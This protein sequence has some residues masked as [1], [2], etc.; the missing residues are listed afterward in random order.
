ME[1][2][3]LKSYFTSFVYLCKDFRYNYNEILT[4]FNIILSYLKGDS[5]ELIDFFI[6][7]LSNINDYLN[8]KTDKFN[9]P[10]PEKFK[11][12]EHYLNLYHNF[13]IKINWCSND[14]ISQ[15]NKYFKDYLEFIEMSSE[16]LY[17][18]NIDDN[19]KVTLLLLIYIP[20]YTAYI[21]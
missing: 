1:E 10:I 9:V 5:K 14:N 7:D 4:T 13:I 17:Y 16:L 8:K 3:N 12:I 11:V 21:I 18:H 19:N 20:L 6:L 15:N 2:N